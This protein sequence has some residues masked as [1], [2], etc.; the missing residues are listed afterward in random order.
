MGS[1]MFSRIPN[2]GLQKGHYSYAN[3]RTANA[4]SEK[5]TTI[6]IKHCVNKK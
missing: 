1:D 6:E 4:I 2:K 5:I 3:G